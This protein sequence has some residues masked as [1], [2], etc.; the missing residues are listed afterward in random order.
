MKL[1]NQFL[2]ALS[3]LTRIP[4]IKKIEYNEKL[5]G[6][7]MKFYPL[8]G[9]ILGILLIIVDRMLVHILISDIRNIFILIIFIY[10]SGGL[11]LDG[12]MDTIDGIFSGKKPDKMRE[13]MHDSQ[14]G[15][16]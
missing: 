5:P 4:V 10:L 11:H 2:F 6:K 14:V 16:F 7:S 9:G 8:I 12:F 13:I 3:F 1:I 15:A